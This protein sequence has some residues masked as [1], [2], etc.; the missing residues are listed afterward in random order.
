MTGAFNAALRASLALALFAPAG[1]G[2][3]DFERRLP[4]QPAPTP[5]PPVPTPPDLTP[6]TDDTTVLIP[7]LQGIVFVA[8]P[9]SVQP[10]GIVPETV[11]NG[12]DA[13]QVPLLVQTGLDARLRQYVGRPLTR[14]DL[15][16]ITRQVQQVYR[17]AD[18]PF[19]DVSVPE[20]NVQRGVVQIIVTEYRVGAVTVT[21][22][23]HFSSRQIL[24]MGNLTPGEPLTLPRLREALDDYNQN[25]FLTVNAIARPGATT[26]SSDIV[27]E[28]QDRLPLRGYAGYDNQGV[29]TLGRDEWFVGLNWGNAFGLGQVLSYQYTRSFTGRY[30]AHSVSDVI[31]VDSND[32]VVLFGAYA[33]QQPFLAEEFSSVGHS[34]QVSGR[35]VHEI[36]IGIGIKTSIQGGIDYKRTDNN[37]EFLGLRLLDS[38][39][40]VFQFPLIFTATLDDAHGQTALENQ[41]VISPG[42]ITRYNKT[43]YMQLLVPYSDASYFYDR[44]SVTR[45]TKLPAGISWIV[46][47]MVQVAS[48]NLPYSEQL[49]AGGIGS[50]RAY[51]PNSALGSEGVLAKTELNAPAF[52]ILAGKGEMTDQM[53]LGV[54]LD[55]G[56]VWQRRALP[57]SPRNTDLMSVGGKAHYTLGR[58]LDAEVDLGQQ[59]KRAPFASDKETRVSA[60]VTLSY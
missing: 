28:A 8:S 37:L 51:D 9:Q 54:F 29:A 34:G 26:G 32:H 43:A 40:E 33:T 52:S 30:D 15:A 38:A 36:P 31:P 12:I 35:W 42:N 27:L 47:A 41:M 1:A 17:S 5:A 45:V 4:Q 20:Q 6:A 25:P 13:R 46:R 16:T 3:Q 24:A 14:G 11:P 23:R 22:N 21:G 48:G 59:L 2:A 56:D 44:L 53:Q 18:R 10:A 50:V 58:Y 19:V 49:A 60:M 39:V 7:T 57:D 55:Y